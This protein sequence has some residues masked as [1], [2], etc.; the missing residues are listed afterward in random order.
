[1]AGAPGAPTKANWVPIPD[2]IVALIE[3]GELSW[4]AIEEALT[5]TFQDLVDECWLNRRVARISGLFPQVLRAG[6]DIEAQRLWHVARLR[7]LWY[8]T[9][10]QLKEFF[11]A[12]D[13]DALF[14][15]VLEAV[16]L[17]PLDP[18][19]SEI[20]D[21]DVYNALMVHA[22]IDLVLPVR[23]VP[24]DFEIPA[25]V[26][27][28]TVFTSVVYN[29]DSGDEFLVIAREGGKKACK[30][31]FAHVADN[32]EFYR[33][34]GAVS[35]GSRDG[36]HVVALSFLEDKVSGCRTLRLGDLVRGVPVVAGD[37]D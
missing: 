31:I 24:T 16:L 14:K 27:A 29:P 32:I 10:P 36:M 30:R 22:F 19:N 6:Y 3:T 26:A 23:E 4:D 9:A 15:T 8:S 11:A 13:M 35:P 17:P 33:R 25:D 5:N 12:G 18:Q 28:F 20:V 1:M 37:D 7:Q 21:R 2:T 34:V